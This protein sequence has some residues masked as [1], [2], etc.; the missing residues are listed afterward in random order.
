MLSLTPTERKERINRNQFLVG[1]HSRFEL[2]LIIHFLTGQS[3]RLTEMYEGWL[4]RQQAKTN[5]V[6]NY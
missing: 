4:H 2:S 5:E 3:E 1:F 6:Q